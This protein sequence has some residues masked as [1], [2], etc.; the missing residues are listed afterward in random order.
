MQRLRTVS[1][2]FVTFF[3]LQHL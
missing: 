1:L 3:V 2:T